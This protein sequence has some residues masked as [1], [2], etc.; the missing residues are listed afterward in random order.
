MSPGYAAIVDGP[1]LLL[2]VGSKAVEAVQL[3]IETPLSMSGPRQEDGRP[4]RRP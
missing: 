3:D 4:G 2:E 1:R